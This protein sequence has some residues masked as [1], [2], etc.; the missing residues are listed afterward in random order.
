MSKLA[1]LIL[2]FHRSPKYCL[3]TYLKCLCAKYSNIYIIINSHVCVW[4]HVYVYV[5]VYS[6]AG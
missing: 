3:P 6:A 5:Y 4:V 1:T 2:G